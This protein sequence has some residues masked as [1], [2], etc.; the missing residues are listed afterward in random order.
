MKKS[1]KIQRVVILTD[2]SQF[3]WEWEKKS[4]M[5]KQT[6]KSDMFFAVGLFQTNMFPDV[7][8]L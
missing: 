3:Q 2:I 1:V 7:W 8:R 6:D 4:T 5:E